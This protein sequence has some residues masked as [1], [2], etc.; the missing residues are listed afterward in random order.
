MG[1]KAKLW[2]I[3][4]SLLTN[5]VLCAQEYSFRYFG[6]SDGLNNLAVRSIYED[7]VGF[8]WVSTENG[9]YRYDGDRFEGF[10]PAQGIPLIS[11]AAFGEAP[12]GSLL[13]GG[14]F[15][16]Y[17]LAGN[18]F[19]KL[20]VPFKTVSWAQGIQADGQG[21]TYIGT[22][23]G[24]MELSR[25]AGSD[26][27]GVRK[28]PAPP[29]TFGA[30][31]GGVLVEGNTLWYGCGLEL[32]RM[33]SSGTK[34]YGPETGLPGTVV[35][36]I[37]RDSDGN[38]WIRASN[39][40]TFVRP[41]GQTRFRRPDSPVPGS[42]LDNLALDADGRVLLGSPGGLLIHDRNGWQTIDRRNGLRGVIYSAFE[43]RQ[44]SMW[45]GMAGRGLVRWRGYREWESYSAESGLESD[46]VY[47]I[48]P[49]ADGSLW[50]ATEGGLVRGTPQKS[51]FS[52]K[53][54]PGLDTMPVH[55]L[56]MTS[57]GDL[58]VG[59]ETRGAARYNPRTGSVEW[60]GAPQ[61]LT[62]KA[63]YTL[64]LDREQNLW[65]ATEVG[66]FVAK[67]PYLSFSRIADVPPA[68]IW[69]VAQGSDG[70]I[71]AGGSGGLFAMVSGRWNNWTKADGLSNQAV[72][73]LGAG[74][75]G[76][77]WIGYRFGGGIDRA[78]LRPGGLAIEKGVQRRGSDGIVYFLNFDRSGRLWAG[79]EHGVDVWDGHRWSHYDMSDGLAWNDC[80]LGG[81]AQGPDGAIWIG[82]SGGLSRFQPRARS[83]LQSP[84]AVV[85]TRLQMGKID[86]FG[87]RGPAFGIHSGALTARYSALNVPGESGAEF[88]Y[89]LDDSSAWTETTERE[90]EFARLAPG[91]YQLKVQARER[92]GEWSPYTAGFAFSILTPWYLQWWFIAGCGLIPLIVVAVTAKLRARVAKRRERDLLRIV[93]E[94]TRDLRNANEELLR[95]STTDALTGLANRRM[96]DQTLARECARLSRAGSALSL[97]ILDVDQF[98]ALND[99]EGH[100]RGDECLVL[101][102]REIGRAA[103]RKADLAARIGGEEFALILPE[104]DAI[105]AA[106]IAQQVRLAVTNLQLRHPASNVAPYLTV[107]AGVATATCDSYYT[108]KD[109]VAAADRAL[110]SAKR[111]GRN[112]VEAA[113]EEIRRKSAG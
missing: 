100:Q 17:R 20:Q 53:K 50:V 27:L 38:L 101:L 41:A 19:E 67:P 107:S 25:E 51:G 74:A 91:S 4:C 37:R 84:P 92:D 15:G 39:A 54:V 1:R 102:G 99:S 63:P 48:L 24:L 8:I 42:A 59:T 88:R 90:L 34:V 79:T 7:R 9:I 82:T 70:T 52:W 3:V 2:L 35:M 72:I 68:R 36:E 10:G 6:N 18:R 105:H 98:K 97:V 104:T 75:H 73:S 66:L 80:D 109:L 21:H 28:I 83:S 55:S 113:P 29:G 111:K 45:I 40:E 56:Q 14:D 65:A 44:H 49:Q 76:E 108:P 26:S 87:E 12:D 85:F 62:G 16:L 57:T 89:R 23:A 32:C 61:G 110:Y 77:M 69:T 96:F 95:L 112:R 94:K 13:A 106:D 58:W 30:A 103:K 5:G 81:F 64:L 47:A 11:A 71:W 43:D 78:H 60:F 93:D 22:D 33:D 46:I 86:V 31:A